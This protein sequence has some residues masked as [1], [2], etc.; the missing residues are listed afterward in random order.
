MSSGLGGALPCSRGTPR[1]WR[2]LFLLQ[3]CTGGHFYFNMNSVAGPESK[4][5]SSG[6]SWALGP[7]NFIKREINVTVEFSTVS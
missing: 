1:A 7:P 4:G 5:G 6:G 2:A 3:E